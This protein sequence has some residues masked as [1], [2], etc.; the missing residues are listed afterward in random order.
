MLRKTLLIAALCFG[1]FGGSA[2]ADAQ[3][4]LRD[5]VDVEGVRQNDLIGYGIARAIQ[6]ETHRSQKTR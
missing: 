4:R 6:F 1:L 5:I 2:P 3:T